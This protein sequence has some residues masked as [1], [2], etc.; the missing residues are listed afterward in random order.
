MVTARERHGDLLKVSSPQSQDQSVN[1]PVPAQGMADSL[2][3]SDSLYQAVLYYQYLLLLSFST[4]FKKQKKLKTN[5]KEKIIISRV[6]LHPGDVRN[7]QGW[8]P[9]TQQQQL[10]TIRDALSL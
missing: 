2:T 5:N 10:W 8:G 3:C 9:Q 7:T 6:V 1:F 4:S